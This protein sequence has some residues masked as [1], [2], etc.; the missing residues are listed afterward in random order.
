MGWVKGSAGVR[1]CIVLT[2]DHPV[3]AGWAVCAGEAPVR[4]DGCAFLAARTPVGTH[5]P[6]AAS[7]CPEGHPT[8]HALS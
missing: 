6:S 4:G 7:V 8:P 1:A 5:R 2:L 3:I